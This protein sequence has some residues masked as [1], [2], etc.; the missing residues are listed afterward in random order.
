MT[1][2]HQFKVVI[3][4]TILGI[5]IQEFDDRFSEFGKELMENMVDF[6]PC[7][8]FSSFDEAKLL[9]LSKM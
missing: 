2:Q 5:H 6:S 8:S 9:K 7:D 3:F 4:N 1:N